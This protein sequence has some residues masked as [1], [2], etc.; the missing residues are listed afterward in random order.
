MVLDSAPRLLAC[1]LAVA[2]TARPGEAS[3]PSPNVV[4][5]GSFAEAGDNGVA[6]GWHL[7]G[8]FAKALVDPEAGP[9]GRACQRLEVEGKQALDFFLDVPVPPRTTFLFRARVRANGVLTVTVGRRRMA[10]S[11][12]G[13][14]QT[15]ADLVRT[16]DETTLRIHFRLAGEADR[17]SVFELSGI[18]LRT[19]GEWRAP[20]RPTFPR[21]R[22]ATAGQPA[23]TVVYPSGTDSG[24]T[25]AQRVQAVV[26][27]HVGVLLPTVPD[28]EATEVERPVLR[29]A[30]RNRNLILI[31]RL[32]TNRAMW[33]AYNR[34]LCA[35]DGHHPGGDG[36]VVRTASNVLRNGCNHVI[37]GGSTGSGVEKAVRRF[38]AIVEDQPAQAERLLELPW[39][40]DVELGGACRTAFDQD[41]RRWAE[42]PGGAGPAKLEPGYGKLVRWYMNAMAYYWSGRDSYLRRTR[43]YLIP[44][45]RDKARTHQYIV[46]FFVRAYDMLDDSGIFPDEQ[47]RA[48]DDLILSDFCHFL[49]GPDLSWMTLFAPPYA[50]IELRN[51]HSVAPWMADLTMADF[52]HDYLPLQGDLA[53]IVAY[54]R[55]EKHPFFRHLTATRWQ[56][57]FPR[58]GASH[59]DE[60]VASLFRYALHHE[61]YEFFTRGHARRALDLP[62]VT[63]TRGRYQ[64]DH[65]LLG[66]TAH[67]Y[68]DGR[69]HTLLEC[70]PEPE[71]LFQNRYVC[72]VHRYRPGPE[73]PAHDA[74]TLAGIRAALLQPHNKRRLHS[75]TFPRHRNPAV[76]PDDAVEAVTFRSDF[77][78]EGDMLRMSGLGDDTGAVT[79]LCS[80]GRR[81]FSPGGSPTL[82][83]GADFYAE[84]NA[85]SVVRTD[86]W[87][88]DPKPYAGAARCEW[89]ADVGQCGGA[90]ITV[91]PFLTASWERQVLWLQPGLFVVRDTVT[92]LEDATYALDIAWHP[93]GM[94][95]WDGD[96]LVATQG[97]ARLNITTLGAEFRVRRQGAHPDGSATSAPHSLRAGANVALTAGQSVAAVTVLEL[98]GTA[99]PR[100]TP[101][102]V[103]PDALALCPKD[104]DARPTF[105]LWAPFRQTHIGTDA[106][107]LV[108]RPDRL[109]VLH[110]TTCEMGG[111]RLLDGTSRRSLRIDWET[112]E[113]SRH[114]QTTDAAPKP[115]SLPD[116]TALHDL[117]HG[118]LLRIAPEAKREVGA[119]VTQGVTPGTVDATAQWS[120]RWVYAGLQ[121]PGRVRSIRHLGH[122]VY[123]LGRQTE[124]AEIRAVRT[125]RLWEPSPLPP[126]LQTALPT[127]DG[128]L[129]PADS[130][131]WQPLAATPVWRASVKTGNYGEA[132]PVREAFQI[133]HPRDL[134]ARFIRGTGVGNLH[135]YEAARPEARTPLKLD[136]A[137][138]DGNGALRILVSPALWPPFLRS[139]TQEDT[140]LALLDTDGREITRHQS[141]F[142]MQEVRP[143]EAQADGRKHV[144]VLTDDARVRVLSPDGALLEDLDLYAMHQRFAQQEGRPNTRHPAGG[145]TMPYS[146]GLW[147]SDAAG[148]PRLVVSRYCAYTFID[149]AGDFEGLLSTYDYVLARLLDRGCD[150]DEDGV[151]EQLCLGKYGLTHLDGSPE[152]YVTDPEGHLFYPQVYRAQRISAPGVAGRTVDGLR[153]H[154]FEPVLFGGTPPRFVLAV[155]ESCVGIYDGRRRKWVFAWT[156]PV[157]IRAATVLN[158]TP[159]RLEVAVST[160]GDLLWQLRW[161][162]SLDTLA[163]FRT[164]PFGGTVAD[165]APSSSAPRALLIAADT[166][167]FRLEAFE[168]LTCVAAGAFQA[169]RGIPLSTGEAVV[170]ATA[171]GAVVRLDRQTE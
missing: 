139:R 124:L 32:G 54:R 102:L 92:A 16:A 68:G 126:D 10:Y 115:P 169:V 91:E 152:P 106:A 146:L 103:A 33:P 113:V 69:Y 165:L 73:L 142:N 13:G 23:A 128:M 58:L 86:R 81:W 59:D 49:T 53:D 123:D 118:L 129:P 120:R 135:Y 44:V 77:G 31:G 40:L 71:R 107:A 35:A 148:R 151:E 111:D 98:T 85:L 168:T 95:S 14:W 56:P 25:L 112:K 133:A 114:P 37:L 88:E 8:R 132:V 82:G 155:R 18:E 75:F 34:F 6:A 7:S 119:S 94:P 134:R 27:D 122:G 136:V 36:Y 170:A 140:V 80:R 76:E 105:V 65:L 51:R 171:R 100:L 130:P 117:V 11:T 141:E 143:L 3:A 157:R 9:E 66:M 150:F 110:A 50:D 2:G 154:L 74:R 138:M 79:D 5:N 63:P 12:P 116:A 164:R 21:T 38:A 163:G 15:I 20:S 29:P 158:Q 28:V 24:R 47:V 161:Q 97:D 109:D 87:M 145:F 125:G 45:L 46:E 83:T 149:P 52:A 147:R 1:A 55:A 137:D 167:L 26:R 39:L 156:P 61:Q 101:R 30:F 144:Y 153:V 62:N 93:A 43:E 72:G 99:G 19:A 108:A 17:H 67:A 159:D 60:I 70:L 90:A 64:D 84:L 160:D 78:P 89:T 48:V 131:L 166:G 96:A 104:T 4:P 121:R 41:E 127:E 42:D 162:D 22:L 57:T